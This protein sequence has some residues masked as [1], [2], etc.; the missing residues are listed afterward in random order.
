VDEVQ[1]MDVARYRRT[2]AWGSFVPMVVFGVGAALQSELFQVASGLAAYGEI[3]D[4][5]LWARL[6][7][8]MTAAILIGAAVWLV[9]ISPG[10]RVWWLAAITSAAIVGVLVRG[11]L[12]VALGVYPSFRMDLVW[13]DVVVGLFCGLFSLAVGVVLADAF[14]RVRLQER[15]AS[16]QALRASAALDALQAEELRVRREVAEGLHGT[17]QHRLVLV[18]AG[19]RGIFDEL[20]VGGGVEQ[21]HVRRLAELEREVDDLREHGVREI[22]QLL[23]P[24]GVSLGVAQAVRMMLQRIP[25]S[26]RVQAHIDE[27]VVEYDDPAFARVPQPIRLLAVRLLE[28]AVSNALRH[29]NAGQIAVALGMDDDH[30]LTIIVDDDGAGIPEEVVFS[31]LE[32]LRER[33]DT[34][35]GALE[36]TPGPLGGARLS[37]TIPLDQS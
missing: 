5:P 15:S 23:Y 7:A 19:L 13:L 2:A 30:V 33:L 20:S 27:S 22:G 31:G 25:S 24:A 26:I 35:G 18:G 32:S 36:L 21:K 37:A 14:R 34:V 3:Y 4:V 29:G 17:V 11:G 6:V 28:E 10:R 8:N 9:P 16:R 12:Q 1:T